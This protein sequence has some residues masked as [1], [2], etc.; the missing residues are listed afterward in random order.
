MDIHTIYAARSLPRPSLGEDILA[1]ISK[2]KISFKPPFRRFRPVKRNDEE[3]NWRN[4]A[5]VAAVR[6]HRLPIERKAE[7]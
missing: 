2:L 5:L 3:D 7:A 1:I 4:H 6:N